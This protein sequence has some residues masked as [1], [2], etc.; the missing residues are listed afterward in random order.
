M[1]L[2]EDRRRLHRAGLQPAGLRERLE[3]GGDDAAPS[4]VSQV[5]ERDDADAV[6]RQPAHHRP[7]PGQSA[8]VRNDVAEGAV[9]RDAESER[10][11]AGVELEHSRPG[12]ARHQR[13]RRTPELL[14]FPERRT[15]NR[16]RFRRVARRPRVHVD[17]DVAAQVADRRQHA[18]HRAE[19]SVRES[20]LLLPLLVLP[21]ISVGQPRRR[22]RRRLER[23]R[24]HAERTENVRGHVVGV[25]H[26]RDA[27]HD[28]PQDRESVVRVFVRE[29]GR[30]RERD[31]GAHHGRHPV[32]GVRQLPVAPRI[33]F[34]KSFRVRQQMTDRDARRVARRIL[35]R[36]QLGHIALRG[37]VERQ[38]AVVAQL[39]DRHCGEAVRHRCD[40]KDGVLVR[41]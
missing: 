33:V 36:L 6:L 2:D 11:S 12:I 13:V 35:Q 8:A 21:A 19:R 32:V 38:L 4:C 41:R 30:V 14:H 25:R 29:A 3:R 18:A 24:R 23:R 7:E 1:R 40:A 10:I 28:P 34:G 16:S 5:A 27:R 31:A 26:A 9:L 20:R 15:S 22:H 39:Q 17:G 37:I